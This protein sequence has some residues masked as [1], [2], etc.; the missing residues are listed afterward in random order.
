M[1]QNFHLFFIGQ[2]QP[3]IINNDHSQIVRNWDFLIAAFNDGTKTPFTNSI[4]KDCTFLGKYNLD[5]EDKRQI[6]KYYPNFC[7]KNLVKV[8]SRSEKTN[9][10]Q[11]D[12][13]DIFFIGE[14]R[15][16][17]FDFKRI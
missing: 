8:V 1:E 12:E 7:F 17:I 2:E 14:K 3:F 13:D 15:S 4:L 9:R 6:E 16:N 10:T 5:D 11:F